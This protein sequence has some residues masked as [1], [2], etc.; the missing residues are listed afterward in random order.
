MAETRQRRFRS[1]APVK[2]TYI[3]E[4]GLQ[5][6]QAELESLRTLKRTQLAEKM[7]ETLENSD[8]EDNERLLVLDEQAML[9]GRI[10][11]L[12]RM[13]A[14]VQVI[15]PQG[16]A[17]TV[18]L[19]STVIVQEPGQASETYTIVGTVEANARAGMISDESPL[20]KALMGRKVGD[21]VLVQAPG[22]NTYYRLVAVS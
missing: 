20:G 10:H 1:E 21:E 19:G 6:L 17:S 2:I 15:R 3:T 8:W 16:T 5:K 4:N 7:R 12:E 13:L 22:G 9:E 18:G 11:E 14:N